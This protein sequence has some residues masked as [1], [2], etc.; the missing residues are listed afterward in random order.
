MKKRKPLQD[1]WEKFQEIA[2]D[3]DR[4]DKYGLTLRDLF[5][6]NTVRGLEP[7]EILDILDGKSGKLFVKTSVQKAVLDVIDEKYTRVGCVFKI[8]DTNTDVK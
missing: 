3:K 4:L 1:R 8:K 5:N 6:I 7:D 2:V